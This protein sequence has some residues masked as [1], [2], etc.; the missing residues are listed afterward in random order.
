[1]K[2][3]PAGSVSRTATFVASC[4]P[5]LA[6]VIVKV[7]LSP[8]LTIALLTTF[9]TDKSVTSGVNAATA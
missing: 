5:A 2:L 1:M 9:V 3:M 8:T 7:T 4:G 6:T